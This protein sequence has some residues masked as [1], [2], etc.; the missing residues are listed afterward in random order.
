MGSPLRVLIVDENIDYAEAAAELLDD[1]GHRT[2]IAD[3]AS[4]AICISK[5]E[6][7]DVVLMDMGLRGTNTFQL[8]REMRKLPSMQFAAFVAAARNGA[9]VDSNQAHS[10]GL[11]HQVARPFDIAQVEAVISRAA[12]QNASAFAPLLERA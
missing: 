10:A 2:W 9:P 1:C 7:P 5:A 8:T 4:D 11:R 3:N 6:W 12:A